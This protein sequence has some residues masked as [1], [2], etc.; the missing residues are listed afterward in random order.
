MPYAA[1]TEK[2]ELKTKIKTALDAVAA[3]EAASVAAG[4]TPKAPGDMGDAN[5]AAICDGVAQWLGAVL[6]KLTVTVTVTG[7]TLVTKGPDPSGP[8]TG[9]GVIS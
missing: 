2:G 5:L 1:A 4:G 9:T 8:G 3:A 6:P 7:V